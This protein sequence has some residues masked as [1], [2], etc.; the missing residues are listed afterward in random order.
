MLIFFLV[1]SIH[2][3]FY[4]PDNFPILQIRFWW[5]AGQFRRVQDPAM[6]V[7][8]AGEIWD[9]YFKEDSDAC[10]K[11]EFFDDEL[12]TLHNSLLKPNNKV[13]D[14]FAKNIFEDVIESLWEKY[15]F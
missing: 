6:L 8:A 12:A 2:L 14:M 7:Q 5:A 3:K 11:D 15:L 10:I 4:S 13:F 1:I 9:K